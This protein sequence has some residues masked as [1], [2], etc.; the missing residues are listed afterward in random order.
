MNKA[1]EAR[2]HGLCS[3][4]ALEQDRTKFLALVAELNRILS[5]QEKRLR[6]VKPGKK[7]C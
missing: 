7:G 2:I 3:L 6:G 1:D 5:E 4:I